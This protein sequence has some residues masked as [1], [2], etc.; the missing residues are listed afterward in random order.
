MYEYTT[1]NMYKVFGITLVSLGICFFS[2]PVTVDAIK[3]SG[4]YLCQPG[5]LVF[6]LLGFL[7]IP[8]S[9]FGFYIDSH[10][11]TVMMLRT[12]INKSMV[13]EEH[14]LASLNNTDL[15]KYENELKCC[16]K[17]RG[18]MDW[19]IGSSSFGC[20]CDPN[21]ESR[22]YCDHAS[23][24]MCKGDNNNETR[25]TFIYT[26]PCSDVV[27]QTISYNLS[28]YGGVGITATI[29]EIFSVFAAL[30]RRFEN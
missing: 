30:K 8:T 12:R 25:S 7:L 1:V 3:L 11:E 22:D 2:D 17:T 13:V 15:V 21:T 19:E 23:A 27:F 24:Q 18:C 29:F 26:Q 28:V 9:I 5:A 20:G 10:K 16:G 4:L 6:T 14:S